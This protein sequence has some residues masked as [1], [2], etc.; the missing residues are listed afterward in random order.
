[1]TRHRFR[2]SALAALLVLALAVLAAG[3]G[4][5]DGGGSTTSGGG[6]ASTQATDVRGSVSVIGIWTGDEQRSFQAV[7]DKFNETYPDVTVRYT[8]AGDNLPTVV[9]TAVEGGNP[10]DI[11]TIAQPGLIRDFQRRGALRPKIGRAHV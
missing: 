3:C 7:I 6:G 9:G 2:F 8:S 11:A 10:P 5:D 4:D 1:M